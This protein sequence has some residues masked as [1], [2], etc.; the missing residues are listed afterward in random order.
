MRLT[1]FLSLVLLV[2]SAPVAHAQE[3]P[4]APPAL[5]GLARTLGRKTTPPS[6]P[7]VFQFKPSARPVFYDT[8]IDAVAQNAEQKKALRQILVEG[9]KAVEAELAKAGHPHDLSAGLAVGL[10]V[11]WELA[12]GKEPSDKAS[13][14]L[15][16]Q[17][18][19]ALDSPE[20]R[21]SGD[22]DKQKMY[23]FGVGMAVFLKTMEE[24]STDAESKKGL[25][26]FAGQFIEQ[27]TGAGPDALILDDSGIRRKGGEA[28][29]SDGGATKAG[30][31]Q[32]QLSAGWTQKKV[33]G[34]TFYTRKQ[35][36]RD[37]PNDPLV[38]Q[39]LVTDVA[40]TGDP[41]ALVRTFYDKLIRP[42]I[43]ADVRVKGEALLKDVNPEI[44]RRLA[45]NGMRCYFTAA[46]WNKKNE[47]IEY[48]GTPQEL[49]VYAV[50]TGGGWQGVFAFLTGHDG[51]DPVTNQYIN[52]GIRNGWLEDALR[53]LRG[54]PSGKPL[55]TV[56]EVVGDFQLSS[57]TLGPYYVN[58]LTGAS[59]GNAMVF[60]NHKVSYKAN[61]AYTSVFVGGSGIGSVTIGSEKEAGTIRIVNDDIGAFLVRKLSDGRERKDR[62]VGLNTMADGRKM[63]INLP[64]GYAP[65]TGW[66]WQY[67]DRYF[68]E[69][70]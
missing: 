23:E 8:L 6:D 54:T 70:K 2:T 7:K 19:S 26:A 30:N 37:W 31:L 61:G 57:N 10:A 35:A 24:L 65:T 45:G 56:A 16:A 49:H 50:E 68:T 44:Y 40:V 22:V 67:A 55:F 64:Q 47:S 36:T 39:V 46:S 14:A 13:D 21:A 12:T 38:L 48:M 4:K 17:L 66:I 29:T 41:N 53:G 25:K 59:V 51:N 28:P 18:R 58:A 15:L 62:L 60:R 34:G 33:D 42:Q 5:A 3:S 32:I 52:S 63:L 11:A 43:P 69:K 20:L 1:P 27:L 9:G